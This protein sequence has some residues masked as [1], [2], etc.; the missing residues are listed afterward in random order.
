MILLLQ[1]TKNL[2]HRVVLAI[3]YSSGLR[4]SEVIDLKLS[5]FDFK[6]NQLHIQNSK[7]RKD[8]DVLS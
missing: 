4:I 5:D 3:L 6:H 8:R 1:A 2:K 7:G